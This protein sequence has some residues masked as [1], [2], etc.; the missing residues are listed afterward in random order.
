MNIAECK[1]KK[2][3]MEVHISQE[4]TLLLREFERETGLTVDSVEVDVSLTC[5]EQKDTMS[6][7]LISAAAKFMV[8]L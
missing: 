8:N 2:A 4:L 3:E 1:K 7:S 5:Y 6:R